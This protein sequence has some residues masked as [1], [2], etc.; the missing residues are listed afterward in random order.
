MVLCLSCC[1]LCVLSVQDISDGASREHSL[2]RQLDKMQGEW[3]GVRLELT[4]WKDTG[5]FILKVIRCFHTVTGRH[6]KFL[7]ANLV[8]PDCLPE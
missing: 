5:G 6:Y 8:H 4:A 3:A 2:E 7:W 1:G